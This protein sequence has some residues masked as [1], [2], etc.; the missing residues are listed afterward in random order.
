VGLSF[1]SWS[2]APAFAQAPP[3]I[4]EE[5]VLDVSAG[6]AT[7]S[8]RIDAHELETEYR[9][10]YGPT[11]SYGQ[12]APVPAASVAPEF[13]GGEV[14]A[15]VQ[16]LL[17]HTTYHF[18]VVVSNS[19]GTVDGNDQTFQTQSTTGGSALPDGRQWEMV[20]P[21]Q[22][23][24][25][26]I[27]AIGQ[28]SEGQVDMIQAAAD[29]GALAYLTSAP[30]EANPKGYA[31]TEELL[32]TRGPAGWAS[33]DISP[34]HT[35]PT[36]L[37]NSA[38]Y[39]LFSPDL[40]QGIVQ[41]HG[42]FEPALS[43]EASEQTAYLR[44]N[45]PSGKA[46]D[47]CTASCYHPLV[48]G[49]LGYA[50]VPPGTV[51]AIEEAYPCNPKWSCGPQFVGAT[52]DLSHVALESFVPLTSTPP[53]EPGERYLYE[54]SDGKLVPVGVLPDGEL[55]SNAWLG[56]SRSRNVRHAISDD[57]SRVFW[58]KEAPGSEPGLYMRDTVKSETV[59]IA[60]SIGRFEYA[61][62]FQTASSD[63]SKVFFNTANRLTADSGGGSEALDMYECEIVEVAGALQCKLSDLTPLSSSGEAASVQGTVLGASE[64]GSYVYFVANGV[65]APG[66]VPG[67]CVNG[68]EGPPAPPGATCNLYVHHDGATKLVAVVSVE[69]WVDWTH[70]STL[71]SLN[72]QSARV[73]SDGRWLAFMSKRELTGYDNHD[74]LSGE[75]DEE[76]Y[77]YDAQSGR[78]VCASCNPTGARPVGA[79][80]HNGLVDGEGNW[81][82]QWL[83]ANIPG[84]T[85]Y[86][87]GAFGQTVYQSRFLSDS[88]RLFFNSTDA[89]VPQDVNSTWDVYQYEPPGVG[90]CEISS[91]TFGERSSGCVGL[92]SSG[93]SAEESAFLDASESGG[94]V[95]MLTVAKL[96][97]QDVDTALDVYDAHECSAA[98]PCIRP[99]AAQPPPCT[100]GD[101][102]KAALTPQ[103]AI[104][105]SPASATFSGA[106]NIG[107][108]ITSSVKRKHF[109]P[110]GS[111]RAQRLAKALKACGR[112][113]KHKRAVCERQ[114]RARYAKQ[115]RRANAKRGGKG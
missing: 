60:P 77:L 76:V 90:G 7:L 48:T 17:A 3:A 6:S 21:A 40:S 24:G 107:P 78:V 91:P 10:E 80:D 104:F 63:G 115:A 93:S 86:Y 54:W 43:A 73:S 97:G 114:A 102:C 96:S 108:S 66:A 101:S 36:G 61:A 29:G 62:W 2:A 58:S 56:A 81:E 37:S 99:P 27:F 112:K 103:P 25:A 23:R 95:F 98:S 11:S 69:D 38:E 68:Q 51:F 83:A 28:G 45:Y 4:E 92:I 12:T 20:S 53:A 52:P 41:P 35:D 5:S 22:K 16:G 75:R 84:W 111:T 89:L 59:Q 85:S 87:P 13:A 79:V 49:K 109:T 74:A 9:F 88:G 64:D 71:L 70:G 33:R 15:H 65:L 67:K 100:T 82:K 106:G 94:D 110:K 19:L 32:S 44:T 39:R 50:N 31:L 105:G 26:L 14:S 42:V 18:R 47:P 46:N 55:A 30:T 57:G 34:P 113:P 8:A 72:L 1:A